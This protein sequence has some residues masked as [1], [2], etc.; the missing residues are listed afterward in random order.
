MTLIGTTLILLIIQSIVN[1]RIKKYKKP[2]NGLCTV[3]HI[4]FPCVAVILILVSI[5]TFTDKNNPIWECENCQEELYDDEEPCY[6]CTVNLGFSTYTNIVEIIF[7]VIALAVI[8]YRGCKSC[9]S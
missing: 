2:I 9:Q 1:T 8:F 7:L 5:T 4:I 6:E 3:L